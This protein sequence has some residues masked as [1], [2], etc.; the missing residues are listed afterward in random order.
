MST[1]V[2]VRGS[3]RAPA[4]SRRRWTGVVLAVAVITIA[5]LVVY[6]PPSSGITY[7]P[8]SRA[9]DGLA[10][11]V[12]VLTE[13][14]VEVEV[15]DR[16]P[17]G[18]PD[19][20]I[21]PPIG[22]PDPAL[23]E[24]ASTG[25]RVVAA[26][27]PTEDAERVEIAFGGIGLVTREVDCAL[28]TDVGTLLSPS[29]IAWQ[30]SAD[31]EVLPDG[32]ER[33]ITDGT[34]A[35]ATVVPVGDG[36]LVSLGSFAPL[37]NDRMREQD[38]AVAAVRLLGVSAGDRVVALTVPDVD[39]APPTLFDI[40]D[41]RWFDA[42]WLTLLVLVLAGLARGRR[43]GRPVSEEL[44]VRV[45]SGELAR[46]MGDLR[47]RVGANTAAVETLRT[48]TLALAGARLGL[49]A[50]PSGEEVVAALRASGV[51][52][53]DADASVLRRPPPPGADEETLTG[54]AARLAAVRATLHHGAAAARPAPP[55]DRPDSTTATDAGDLPADTE[56]L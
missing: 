47:H 54:A 39:D 41:P 27:P 9:P 43:L 18:T 45:P 46:A 36:R 15:S 24:L 25:P 21:A 34:A 29:W 52:L 50:A 32:T 12:D 37:V 14:D 23:R 56:Q 7:D 44:P 16:L 35:W 4:G 49:G 19:A 20:V 40:I 33:C 22:W 1:D 53:T 17:S 38:A 30:P 48:R 55:T 3:G 5:I 6:E 10:V 31:G 51:G 2:F 28:L 42:A 11:L 26:I 13:L 8:A